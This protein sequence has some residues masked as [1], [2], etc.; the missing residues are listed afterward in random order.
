[1]HFF[2]DAAIGRVIRALLILKIRINQ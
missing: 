1:M 2:I